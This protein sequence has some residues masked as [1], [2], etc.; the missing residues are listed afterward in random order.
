MKVAIGVVHGQEIDGWFFNSMIDLATRNNDTGYEITEFINIR[1]GP[2]LAAGRGVLAGSFL[3]GTDADLLVTLDSDMAFTPE[4]VFQLVDT[5]V[6]QRTQMPELGVLGGLAFISNSPTLARPLPN[7]WIEHQTMRGEFLQLQ[8]FPPG[9]LIEVGATGGACLCIARD[10]LEKFAAEKINPYHHVCK[11]DY[12]ALARQIQELDDLSAIEALM[13]DTVN[14]ADQYGEDISFCWRVKDL[15]YRILV[16]TGIIF[17]HSKATLLG[18]LQ[19]HAALEAD[20][21]N[22]DGSQKEHV[23]V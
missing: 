2:L 17:D 22:P 16:H 21:R 12:A 8:T 20:G 15:G 19:Y 10:V 11:V 6:R 9:A 13:R 18:E 3:E 23:N 1:S 7:L 14:R 4:R 5:F